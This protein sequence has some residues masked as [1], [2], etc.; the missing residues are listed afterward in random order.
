MVRGE[1]YGKSKLARIRMPHSNG[2]TIL[3]FGGVSVFAISSLFL[4]LYLEIYPR[5]LG[6][7]DSGGKGQT[8]NY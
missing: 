3:I 1:S 2:R 7:L 5:V 6:Y 8:Q 4:P